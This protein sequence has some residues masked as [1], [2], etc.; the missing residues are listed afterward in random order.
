MMGK[1]QG[2]K[3][4]QGRKGQKRGFVLD[5]LFVLCVLGDSI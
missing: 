3:G 2:P 4:Q 1:N 5:V